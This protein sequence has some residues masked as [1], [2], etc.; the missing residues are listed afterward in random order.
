MLS[1]NPA[2][3]P[4][5]YNWNIVF[6]KYCCGGMWSAETMETEQVWKAG[7]EGR[8]WGG[9]G[10]KRREREGHVKTHTKHTHSLLLPTKSSLFRCEA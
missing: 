8:R 7:S 9:G 1:S 10:R 6:V 5:L 3:N 4:T 2:V